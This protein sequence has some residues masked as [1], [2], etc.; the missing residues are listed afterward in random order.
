[1]VQALALGQHLFWTQVVCSGQQIRLAVVAPQALSFLQQTP[2]THTVP[3]GQQID[4]AVPGT[5]HAGLPS[6]QT[7][8]PSRQIRPSGQQIAPFG[9]LQA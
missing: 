4:S 2:F 7:Q 8:L 9:V 1:M 6:G 5:A 3:S